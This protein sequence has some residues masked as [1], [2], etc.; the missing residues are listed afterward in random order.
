[1]MTEEKLKKSLSLITDIEKLEYML[2]CPHLYI[3]NFR[4]FP[5]DKMYTTDEINDKLHKMLERE[6][7][8][9]KKEFEKL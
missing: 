1:M 7:R 6:L 3:Y 9:K 4:E 2:E 5:W 8:R